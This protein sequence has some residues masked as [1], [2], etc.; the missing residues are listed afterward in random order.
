MTSTTKAAQTAAITLSDAL[1]PRAE[2]ASELNRNRT[3]S[4]LPVERLEGR[5][6]FT[7]GT[8]SITFAD[9]VDF[10]AGTSP[11]A[12]VTADFNGD[13][14]P[15][16]AVADHTA[17]AVRLYFSSGAAAFSPGPVLQLA[18]APVALLV[19]DFNGDKVTD[20]AALQASTT[21][22][23]PVVVTVFLATGNNT[24][25]AGI[26]TTVTPSAPANDPVAFTAADLDGDKKLDLA[27]TDYDNTTVN[28]LNGDGTG[29]FASPVVY[30]GNSNP[31][32]IAAGKFTGQ[33]LPDLVITTSTADSLTAIRTKSLSLLNN[34]GTGQFFIGQN[35]PLGTSDRGNAIAVADVTGAGSPDVVVGSSDSTATILLN[36]GGE[37]EISAAPPLP[38]GAAAIAVGDFNRDG[39]PDLVSANGGLSVQS[40]ANSISI[41]PGTGDGNYAAGTAFA[42]G[43]QPSAVVV[44]DFNGD[45]KPDVAT[46]NLSRGNRQR[47]VEHDD[48]HADRDPGEGDDLGVVGAR[49]VAGRP[50]RHHHP[51]QRES[52]SGRNYPHGH[53]RFLRRV[54]LPRREHG[55]SRRRH[56]N[57]YRNQA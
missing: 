35:L 48:D 45:A 26:S 5:C 39:T 30:T 36:T 6:Y 33:K 25:S 19:G 1:K 54:H 11:I 3:G 2:T 49:G 34:D 15:D 47:A 40:S 42:T 7:T 4:R 8:A 14:K 32:S 23:S 31:T 28:I 44:A 29:K 24:F 20:V 55:H 21:A 18:S 41:I 57:L 37:F 17:N 46:A 13:G 10:A 43:A 12:M 9:H 52:A 22:N 38:A 50:D 51:R 53:G 27:V 56:C 16:L